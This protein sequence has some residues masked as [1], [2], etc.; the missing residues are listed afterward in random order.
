MGVKDLYVFGSV[1][2]G[3]ANPHD[4]DILVHFLQPPG[5]LELTGVR[6]HLE[7]LLGIPV[8][9]YTH[10]ACPERFKRRIHHELQHVA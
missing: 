5:L 9:V 2:R 1:A 3:E 6:F 10:T 7:D 8:D 4:V